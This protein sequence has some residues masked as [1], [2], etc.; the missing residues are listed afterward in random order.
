VVQIGSYLK[1][2]KRDPA[3]LPG[4]GGS[5]LV[6]SVDREAFAR[7]RRCLESEGLQAENVEQARTA[8]RWVSRRRFDLVVSTYPLPDMLL[9]DFLAAL[10]RARPCRD[11]PLLLFT[12]PE[13][14]AEARLGAQQG[15]CRVLS[16]S[17]DPSSVCRAVTQLLRLQPRRPVRAPVSVHVPPDRDDH[18]LHGTTVNLSSSGMLLEHQRMLPVKTRCRFEFELG[19][20]PQPF[21]GT[22]EVVRHSSPRRERAVG[23]ALRF[24]SFDAGSAEMLGHQLVRA[25]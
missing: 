10:R 8:L 21:A 9:G 2:W 11:T 7:V 18:V 17:E 1:G 15:P 25:G 13:R 22:G 5:L 3:R 19:S 20:P 14:L 24:L 23:F 6:G 16:R 4:D 12:N